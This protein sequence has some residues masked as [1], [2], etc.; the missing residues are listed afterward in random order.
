MYTNILDDIILRV[1]WMQIQGNNLQNQIIDNGFNNSFDYHLSYIE[2]EIYDFNAY[3]LDFNQFVNSNLLQKTPVFHEINFKKY[4]YIVPDRNGKKLITSIEM[5]NL[6]IPVLLHPIQQNGKIKI[7]YN[8]SEYYFNESLVEESGLSYDDYYYTSLGYIG[9]LINFQTGY[10]F[11]NSETSHLFNSK[12]FKIEN[13]KLNKITNIL[14]IMLCIFAGY[15]FVCWYIFYSQT[16]HLFSRYLVIHTQLRFF[17]NYLLKKTII[18]YE[19][20]DNNYYNYNISSE[21]SDIEF[22]NDIEQIKIIKN[23]C[24]GNIENYKLIKIRPLTIKFNPTQIKISINDLS[25]RKEEKSKEIF[26]NFIKNSG[27]KKKRQ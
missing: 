21:I 11:F 13:Q 14:L 24:S 10:K 18:I 19:Y 5:K 23:I 17:N 27:Q 4:P 12:V 25:S 8:N 20:I 2:N 1:L 16:T 9:F 22:E 6:H 26:Q 7:Y 15:N 3:F